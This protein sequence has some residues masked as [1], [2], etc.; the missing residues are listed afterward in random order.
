MIEGASLVKVQ[1]Y[2]PIRL[3]IYLQDFKE[4]YELSGNNFIANL[5]AIQPYFYRVFTKN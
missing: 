4:P 3:T 5:W 1:T 2:T